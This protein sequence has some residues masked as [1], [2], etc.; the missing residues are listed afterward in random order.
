MSL[1]M[2]TAKK[3]LILENRIGRL[4]I[5]VVWTL[6]VGTSLFI[7]IKREVDEVVEDATTAAVTT[8]N[9]DMSF[10]KWVTGHG[11]VYV[12]I[13]ETQKPVPF[14]E[15]IDGRDV[16]TTDGLELTLLNPASVVRQ[17]MDSYEK[18]FGIRGRITGLKQL[19]PANAP[20][21]WEKEQLEAFARGEKKEASMV[22]DIAGARY[23]RHLRAMYMTPGCDKCHADLGYKTG[24]LRGAIG[25]NIPLESYEIQMKKDKNQLI[26]T[27]SVVWIFGILGIIWFSWMTD[28]YKRNRDRSEA[29][30]YEQRRIFEL[31][32]EQSLAGY[33]DWWVQKNEEYLSPS[34]KKMFGYEDYEMPNTPESWQ[35][36]IFPEDLLVVLEVFNRHV[37]SR[38]KIPFYNEVRYQHKDG[39]TVWVICTGRVIEWDNQGQP[40]RMIGCHIDI[41]EMKHAEEKIRK[42]NAE[43]ER[44]IPPK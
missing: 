35:K 4:V 37:K 14:L 33:W 34:F 40:I 44:A 8:L 22:N 16:T 20:D 43:L 6:L 41:T 28:R 21:G 18:E 5:V 24:D 39:S 29:A 36:I 38:G 26:I 2:K 31:I 30:I 32:L 42:L 10:R 17:V 9:K 1:D 11:G 19:N 7:D 23:M 12:P 27:R 3:V 15:H 13:T 25:V